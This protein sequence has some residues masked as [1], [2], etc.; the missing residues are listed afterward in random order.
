MSFSVSIHKNNESNFGCAIATELQEFC[1]ELNDGLNLISFPVLP[2]VLDIETIFYS[3][4]ESVT[5]IISEGD[6]AFVLPDGI[7]L[8]ALKP[9]D[10]DVPLIFAFPFA[11][12]LSFHFS[13]AFY[14]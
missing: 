9:S 7:T 2:L 12:L 3:I 14:S 4:N 5:G 6:A 10:F 8:K 1:W 13:I 11:S